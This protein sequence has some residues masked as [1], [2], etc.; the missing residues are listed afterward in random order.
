AIGAYLD[1]IESGKLSASAAAQRLLPAL[2]EQP[3]TPPE[4]LANSLD[5]LQNADTGFLD[6]LADEVLARFPDKVEEYRK[7]KKGLIGFFMG[8]LMKASKG[9]AEPGA[10]NKILSEKLR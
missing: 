6:Q 10:A 3:G 1:L 8:E 4:Q 9:K 7:G 2:L 5:L